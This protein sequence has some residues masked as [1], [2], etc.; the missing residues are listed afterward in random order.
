[1]TPEL[2]WDWVTFMKAAGPYAVI[3]V[4][5]AVLWNLVRFIQNLL[6]Q[7]D[8]LQT[9][10]VEDLRSINNA[11]LEESKRL[12]EAITK[13]STLLEGLRQRNG[14]RDRDDT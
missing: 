1:M 4:L 10:R 2:A 5:L 14:R 12:T 13:L 11:W 7:N 9:Q 6:T 8:T 3:I